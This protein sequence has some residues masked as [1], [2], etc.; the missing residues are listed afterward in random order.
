MLAIMPNAC[1]APAGEPFRRL[2]RLPSVTSN[3][4]PSTPTPSPTAGVQRSRWLA[5]ACCIALVVLGLAWELVLAPTGRGTL[6]I[7]VLPLLLAVPGLWRM[8]LYTYRWMS[9]AVWMYFTEGVVRATSEGGLSAWLAGVEVLLSVLLFVA[10][11]VHVRARLAA[12]RV[13]PAEAGLAG[14][15]A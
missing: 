7:K 15:P 13:T 5:F 4:P 1:H 14:P 11:A 3:L 8:R 2:S 6:A 12:A 9:L 10:C